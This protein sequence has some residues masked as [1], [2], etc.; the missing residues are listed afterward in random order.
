MV[1]VRDTHSKSYL[2]PPNLINVRNRCNKPDLHTD[3][4]GILLA[5]REK[6]VMRLYRSRY[7]VIAVFWL[8]FALSCHTSVDAAPRRR[9]SQASQNASFESDD[10]YAVLGLS[11]T[12]KAKDI[13]SAYRKLALKYH[14]DKVQEE[15]KEKSE[16]IFVNVSVAYAVLSD[17]EKR[18]IYDKYGKPGLEAYERGQDPQAAGF[19]SQGGGSGEGQRPGGGG[20]KFHFQHGGAAFDPFDMFSS[21]FGDD[22]GGGGNFQFQ[23]G[24]FQQGS[25]RQRQ[26]PPPELFPKG[27]GDVT[28]LGSPKFP[29]SKSK[30]LWLVIFYRNDVS[31]CADVKPQVER[32]AEKMKGS[33]KVGAIN[34][35]LNAKEEAFCSKKKTGDLPAFGFVVDGKVTLFE[36]DEDDPPLPSAS[37]LHDFALENMPKKLVKNIN[38]LSQIDDRLFEPLR[39]KKQFTGGVLLLTDKYETS[40]MYYSLAYQFRGSL[41]FGESRAKNLALSK[42]FG[43]KKYPRLVVFVPKGSGEISYDDRFDLMTYQGS[44]KSQDIAAWLKIL[45]QP[46]KNTEL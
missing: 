13:K 31:E 29:D 27:E 42:H 16:G 17:E 24:G 30:H 21:M 19:G 46:G 10:Y 18:S 15:D 39:S 28:K 2:H 12:A 37:D 7:S 6:Q 23:S 22:A 44:P 43:V 32:L 3:Q 4:L 20:Q 25:R 26:G 34:C 5:R 14:P 11:R 36:A 9:K 8:V 38:S 33:Y 40:A 41:V 45:P 35:S 1:A